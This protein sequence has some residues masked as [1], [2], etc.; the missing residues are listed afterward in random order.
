MPDQFTGRK[1]YYVRNVFILSDGS[2]LYEI[3]EPIKWSD[4]DIQILWDPSLMGYKFEFSD[5]DVL[6]EFDE[7]A[8]YSLI[9]QSYEDKFEK[10]N[11]TL[12][13]G[14]IDQDD[15]MTV[16]FEAKLNFD[17][18]I[19]D[20][21]VIKMNCERRSFADKFRTRF[22]TK[23]NLFAAKS[24]DGLLLPELTMR[25]LFLHPRLLSKVGN[26]IYNDNVDP[27]NI[28][29]E[30][31]IE[32]TA[33][34][35]PH[36]KTTV[37]PFK[38]T[39]SNVDDLQE[40]VATQGL[41]IYTGTSLPLGVEKRSFFIDFRLPF[42]FTMGNA[43]QNIIA[44]VTVYKRSNISGGTDDLYPP[45]IDPAVDDTYII[46]ADD[47]GNLAGVKNL[48]AQASGVIDL[49][50]DEALFIKAFIFTPDDALFSVTDFDYLQTE[51]AFLT[52]K[53]QTVFQPSVI[54]TINIHDAVNRQLEVILDVPNPLKS[55][56]LGNTSQGYAENG[57][58]SGHLV[59]DG[60]G[61]RG[62]PNRPF[63]MSAKEWTGS[64]GSLFCMGLSIERDNDNNEFVR[65][66]PLEY[67]FRDVLLFSFTV[68]SQYEKRP[69]LEY[70]FNE[71]SFGFKKYPQDNQQDSIEDWMTLFNYINPITTVKN[72][73]SKIIDWILS[74]YYIEYTRREGF[75]TNPS[76]AYETD[77][78]AFL[79]AAKA[80]TNPAPGVSMIFDAANDK[81]TIDGIF[82][83]AAFDDFVIS[84]ATGSVTNG[85]YRALTVNITF[86]YTKTIITTA[87]G[88][89]P[90]T[91]AGTGDIQLINERFVAERDEDFDLI[92]NVPFPKSVYNLKHHIK[93]ILLRWAK[94]FN[95]GL[96]K[97][98]SAAPSTVGVQFVDGANN[99]NVI[100][101]LK[102]SVTCRYGSVLEGYADFGVN[103]APLTLQLPLFKANII[104]Y[105][106]PITWETLNLIRMA[107][108]GRHPDDLNYGYVELPNP[109][110]IIEKGFIL[111]MK[112]K[113]TT[114]MVKVTLIEKYG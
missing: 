66:E 103:H 67:F 91:G 102:D 68:I 97:T 58:G 63:N 8:G 74:P 106:A 6:L 20:K 98:F 41:L 16:L 104:T 85:F 29:L 42:R 25:E 64:L 39:S 2:N 11:M 100:T 54:D 32:P 43:S 71:M 51:D 23:A 89:V 59:R 48:D 19:Q 57:C 111:D 53:E 90:S 87:P 95:A 112:F 109:D 62:L 52:I 60:L 24:I 4:I 38:V 65:Y 105:E 36:Y 5:Q 72:K 34:D 86:D 7:A 107:F 15:V 55:N 88:L 114:Q 108:E 12:L 113:P 77:K 10:M 99:T 69:A 13:F 21:Y 56:F 9:K 94:V 92:Q 1:L 3:D 18:Y 35:D 17:S 46:S 47:F 81:I 49:F 110:G 61:V 30:D 70:I 31:E 44:G 40:P 45:Q 75:K 80:H 101:A 33:G 82:P 27:N 84:N 22:D 14:E 76:N 50:A 79:F 73:M 83:L 28:P 78:D 26:F 96:F 37:P 93:R